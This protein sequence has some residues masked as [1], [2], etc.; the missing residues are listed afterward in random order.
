M[1]L[2]TDRSSQPRHT[3]SVKGTARSMYAHKTLHVCINGLAQLSIAHLSLRL[4]P[5]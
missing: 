3:Q 5:G 1:H 2:H 4:A